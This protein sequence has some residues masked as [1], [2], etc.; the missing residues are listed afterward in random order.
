MSENDQTDVLAVLRRMFMRAIDGATLEA[1]RQY[2]RAI[3]AVAEL[4]KQRDAYENA[5]H[6]IANGDQRPGHIDYLSKSRMAEIARAAL[7]RC[8]DIAATQLDVPLI[9]DQDEVS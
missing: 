5:L 3:A 9:G 1:V 7:A 2:S 8:R 6:L 4:I